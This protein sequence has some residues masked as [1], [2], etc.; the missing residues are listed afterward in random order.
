M[1]LPGIGN[2]SVA[3]ALDVEHPS[4]ALKNACFWIRGLHILRGAPD[5]GGSEDRAGRLTSI[6]RA[7]IGA[8]DD[9]TRARR[10]RRKSDLFIGARTLVV[11][12]SCGLDVH[13][14]FLFF[15]A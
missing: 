15:F 3:I 12:L 6:Y 8:G 2:Q 1:L 9:L 11:W 14:S 7:S 10:D 13:L 5:D 4:A